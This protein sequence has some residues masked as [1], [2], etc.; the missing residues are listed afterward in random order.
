VLPIPKLRRSVRSFLRRLARRVDPPHPDQTVGNVTYSQHG[1]DLVLLVVFQTIGIARP[2]YLDIGAHHPLHISNTALFY[3]RGSR[4]V[5]VEANPNLIEAFLHCRP[6]DVTLNVAVADKPGQLDFYFIDDYSGR[7]TCDLA[8]AE[9]FVR[10]NPGF[11]IRKK[12]SVPVTTVADIYQQ[13]FSPG[14]VDLLSI[15]I[16]G[17]DRAVIESTFASGIRPKVVVVEV[18]S[19]GDSSQAE[20]IRTILELNGYFIFVRLCANYIAVRDEFRHL[21]C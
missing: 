10:K 3:Q 21:L 2:R 12:T 13:H 18:V 1:E 19:G 4:G 16:E 9:E 17:L 8:T 11:A 5:N 14:D 15:D 7:N 6:E 20:A